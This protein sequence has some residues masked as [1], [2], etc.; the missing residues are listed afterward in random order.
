MKRALTIVGVAVLFFVLGAG[1]VLFLKT[2]SIPQRWM[3]AI[4]DTSPVLFD[5]AA[6]KDD[7]PPPNPGK[8]E[9]R[10]KFL[11]RDKGT[12]IG[13]MLKLPIKPNPVS[14]L[15]ARYRQMTK[16]ENGVTI[17][18]PDQ[19]SYTG[20]FTF[21]LKDADGFTLAKITGPEETVTA[22]SDNPLQG[23]TEE[24]VPRSIA[25]RTKQIA[26]SFDA[27]KCNLCDQ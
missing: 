16:L 22:A 25:E 19:V 7:I 11:D 20:K 1:L 5:M 4:P 13:Y 3:N 15:P 24:T 26:V 23:N 6:M 21:I 8:L 10:V 27:E 18:P 2:T 9:G 12:Q 17:G 14:A